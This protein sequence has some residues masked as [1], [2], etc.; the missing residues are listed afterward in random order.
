MFTSITLDHHYCTAKREISKLVFTTLILI[1]SLLP[2]SQGMTSQYGVPS[3]T[4]TVGHIL[5]QAL[6]SHKLKPIVVPV[7]IVRFQK[8]AY[9]HRVTAYNAVPW[10]TSS[11]PGIAACGPNIP[12][13][14]ALSQ[15]LFF[16]PNGGNRCGQEVIIRLSDGQVIHG[17][18]WD[19]MNAEWHDAADLLT[20][21]VSRAIDFGNHKGQLIFVYHYTKRTNIANEI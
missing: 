4:I 5:P 3:S 13:Q 8:A 6:Q 19:T 11:H 1:T 12:N 15:N 18:V 2:V 16:K 9:L 17:T 21:G 20:N 14:I 7:P 10:Q